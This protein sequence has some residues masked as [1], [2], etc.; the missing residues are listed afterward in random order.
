MGKADAYLLNSPLAL[1]AACRAGR[2]L[3]FDILRVKA[4]PISLAFPRYTFELHAVLI[5]AGV[6]SS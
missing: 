1:E 2:Q 6:L 5:Y 4:P 3:I